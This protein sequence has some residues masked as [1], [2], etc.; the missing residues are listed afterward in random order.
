[1]TPAPMTTTSALACIVNHKLVLEGRQSLPHFL[2]ICLYWQK[3]AG[4][5]N[6]GLSHLFSHLIFFDKKE[7]TTSWS[8]DFLGYSGTS[9]DDQSARLPTMG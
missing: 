2:E 9:I 1:M 3:Q 6:G 8:V 7:I 4:E 5:S